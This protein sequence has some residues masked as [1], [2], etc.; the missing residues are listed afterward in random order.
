MAGDEQRGFF[1]TIPGCITA[2]AGMVTAV[3]SLIAILVQANVIGPRRDDGRDDPPAIERGGLT[4]EPENLNR[5]ELLRTQEQL[6]ELQRQMAA[7]LGREEEDEGDDAGF[8][9][10]PLQPPNVAGYWQSPTGLNYAIAQQ[11]SALTI[12]E[13]NP[14]LGVTAVGNGGLQGAS[15]SFTITTAA[16]TTGVAH[17]R[18]SPDGR[19]LVG[20]YQDG[21]TG[22]VVPLQL[23]R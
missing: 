12:Q 11:G 23:F 7:Q 10:M 9:D 5:Q 15:L 2:V 18:L 1:H 21:V 22:V 8:A 20:Q 6:K 16:G 3:G 14:L 13:N 4:P 19:Q 17:L